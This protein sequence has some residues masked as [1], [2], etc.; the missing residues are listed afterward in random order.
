[1]F[2]KPNREKFHQ[3]EQTLMVLKIRLK[4]KDRLFF[5]KLGIGL[6][7]KICRLISKYCSLHNYWLVGGIKFF[8]KYMNYSISLK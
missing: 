2:S 7:Q 1:M 8:N 6:I 3:A 5:S 4:L